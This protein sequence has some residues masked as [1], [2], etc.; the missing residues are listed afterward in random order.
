MAKAMSNR[1]QGEECDANRPCRDGAQCAMSGRVGYCRRGSYS[2]FLF[3]RLGQRRL[4]WP[5]SFAG[6]LGPRTL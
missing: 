5:G 1:F 2:I 3:F 6:K 4:T